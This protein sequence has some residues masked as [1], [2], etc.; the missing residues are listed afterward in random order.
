M[1]FTYRLAQL[2]ECNEIQDVI[3]QSARELAAS[4][5]TSEQIELALKGVWG[6]DTQLIRP[7]NFLF[8]NPTH[9]PRSLPS[10]GMTSNRSPTSPMSAISK[11]GASGSLLIA[12]I[13]PASL[14]P[15]RC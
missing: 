3:N 15:V 5:Y 4:D 13:V 2:D 14:I 1:R 8:L 6:L 10:S 11:I 12:T 7:L 9:F